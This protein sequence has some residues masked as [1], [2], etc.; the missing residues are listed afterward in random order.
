MKYAVFGEVTSGMDVLDKIA[1]VET[2]NM[3]GAFQNIPVNA[4]IIE[5]MRLKN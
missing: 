2:R 4:V 3:G 5:S 1:E